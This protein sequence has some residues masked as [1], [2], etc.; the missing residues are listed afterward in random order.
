[1]KPQ[2]GGWIRCCAFVVGVA[3]ITGSGCS[4]VESPLGVEPGALPSTSQAAVLGLATGS[5]HTPSG[6]G[7]RVFTFTAHRRADGSAEGRFRIG[8]NAINAWFSAEVTCVSFAGNTAWVAGIID[9]TNVPNLV[10]V[11]SVSEFYVIDNGEGSEAAAD[12]V[13]TALFNQPAGA[14]EPFCANQ[15]L[16]LPPRTVTQGDVQVIDGP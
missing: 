14:D 1:M 11:G 7:L 10:Q 15:P 9:D 6:G 5:G 12:I 8:L 4:E 13:S 3:L 16:G 2:L